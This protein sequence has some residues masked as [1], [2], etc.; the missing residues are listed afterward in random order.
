MLRGALLRRCHDRGGKA[1][2]AL[3]APLLRLRGV[4]Y[5]SGTGWRFLPIKRAPRGS[6]DRAEWRVWRARC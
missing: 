4:V 6:F 3:G 2:L 5:F 1:S